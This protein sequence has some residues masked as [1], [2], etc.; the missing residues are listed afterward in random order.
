MAYLVLVRHGQSEW[1]ALGKWT[2]LT[3][4]ELTDQGREE[5]KTAAA[6]LL[7]MPLHKAHTSKLKRAHQT[8]DEIKSALSHHELETSQHEALNER[9]YG[10]HTGKNKW[11]VQAEIGDE[12][13]HKLRRHWNHPVAGGETLK[14]VHERAIPYYE[15]H[16][17]ADLRAG[18]N[19]I[20]S[21]HG[22]SLRTIMKHLEGVPDDLAHTVEIGTGEVLVYNIH[23][24]GTVLGKEICSVG[25]HA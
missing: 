2:G 14:Q 7:G 1:N 24:D 19:V 25:G 4:V 16:I 5:A 10:E 17:A 13:F 6:S 22:N 3:D 15:E 8:L 12:E 21:A 18:H 23:A 20:V 9:D 11:E